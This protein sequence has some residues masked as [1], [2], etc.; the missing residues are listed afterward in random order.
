INTKLISSRDK[1]LTMKYR[2]DKIKKMGQ[3][4]DAVQL[5]RD[6]HGAKKKNQTGK[7]VAIN[8]QHFWWSNVVAVAEVWNAT[9][10][11]SDFA[12][13]HGWVRGTVGLHF[14]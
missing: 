5:V 8:L 6:A 7:K 2:N 11:A 1:D 4:V 9:E 3:C 10:P 12:T 14:N 13:S